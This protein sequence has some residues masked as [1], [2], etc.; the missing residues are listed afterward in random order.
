MAILKAKAEQ[1]HIQCFG[2]FNCD[3][4]ASPT[5]SAQ[6]HSS[7]SNPIPVQTDS[8]NFDVTTSGFT[9]STEQSQTVKPSQ[10]DDWNNIR[11][12]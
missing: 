9:E 12:S 2:H 1:F 4:A 10:S 7:I 8:D 6:M 3:I 5:E 11:R